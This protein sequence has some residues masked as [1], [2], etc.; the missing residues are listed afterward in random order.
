MEFLFLEAASRVGSG[1]SKDGVYVV[2]FEA[3]ERAV[4]AE[5]QIGESDGYRSQELHDGQ[6]A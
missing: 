6:P 3:R 2:F 1:F 4:G 5:S